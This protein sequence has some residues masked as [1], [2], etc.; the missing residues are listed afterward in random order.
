MRQSKLNEYP[1]KK[2]KFRETLLIFKKKSFLHRV[3][4]FIIENSF[5]YRNKKTLKYVFIAL[6][7]EIVDFSI[8]FILT[9]FL[10]I[11]YIVSGIISY[12]LAVF[13]NYLLN[14]KFTYK[15]APFNFKSRLN[16]LFSYFFV[17]LTGLL[18]N[19]LLLAFAVEVIGLNYLL[20]K[21][22]INL[23]VFFYVYSGHNFVFK[24]KIIKMHK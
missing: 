4:Y 10:G 5:F 23:L 21:I 19:I 1:K 18:I 24:N 12:S 8:L 16:S 11:F 15:F 13:S 22:I 9:H 20:A 2:P 3:Y 17:S 7:G 14:T 6:S